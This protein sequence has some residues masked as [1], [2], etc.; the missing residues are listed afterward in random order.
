MYPGTGESITSA[1]R[2]FVARAMAMHARS[3]ERL[4]AAISFFKQL[5]N[6]SKLALTKRA[7]MD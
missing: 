7:K 5:D 3:P 2:E 6:L 4:R 1:D